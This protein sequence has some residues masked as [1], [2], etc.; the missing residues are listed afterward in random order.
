MES[1]FHWCTCVSADPNAYTI[2][3]F[4]TSY[5]L[6]N[7]LAK[8]SWEICCLF[9]RQGSL[10]ASTLAQYSFFFCWICIKARCSLFTWLLVTTLPLVLATPHFITCLG[11]EGSRIV[12]FDVLKHILVS[13]LI[14]RAWTYCRA[15][16]PD[17]CLWGNIS[18]LINTGIIFFLKLSG[19]GQTMP[20][21]I[22]ICNYSHVLW[23]RHHQD[24]IVEAVS[25]FFQLKRIHV[26][27]Q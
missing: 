13:S 27:W 15:Y 3:Q 25:K 9:P 18:L 2:E 14:T 5:C 24:T 21:V 6:L 20:C 26:G 12:D 19:A 22:F 10:G 16:L 1:V 4:L 23:A 7:T 8:V 17:P 11:P